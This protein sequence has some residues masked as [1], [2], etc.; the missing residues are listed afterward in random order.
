MT[1]PIESARRWRLLLPVIG[2]DFLAA[3]A[4]PGTVL[5]Q[6][7]QHNHVALIHVSAAK[8]RDIPRAGVMRL[9]RRS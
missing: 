5:L 4:E 7:R 6:A 9:G 8:T 1:N 2:Q 3:F